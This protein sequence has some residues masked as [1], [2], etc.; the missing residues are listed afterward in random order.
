M[1]A[2]SPLGLKPDLV[3]F[4]D[5]SSSKLFPHKKIP[6]QQNEANS[7]YKMTSQFVDLGS[8]PKF[9]QEVNPSLSATLTLTLI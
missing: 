8:A 6:S 5:C 2:T 9:G 3:Y 7:L 1:E 4:E